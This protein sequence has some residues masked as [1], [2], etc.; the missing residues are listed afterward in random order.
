MLLAS[1]RGEATASVETPEEQVTDS[2]EETAKVGTD[3]VPVALVA[4]APA[5]TP[6]EDEEEDPADL[7]SALLE[8]VAPE[9]DA[10]EDEPSGDLTDA[11][12][13]D[14][15]DLQALVAEP[16]PPEPGEDQRPRVAWPT[17]VAAVDTVAESDDDSDDEEDVEDD[18]D[19]AVTGRD[20]KRRSRYRSRSAQLPRLGNQAKSNMTTM[21]NLRKKSRGAND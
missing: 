3:E 9:L 4:E 5:E 12:A 14:P 17:P 18:D 16:S 7:L 11:S 20:G 15:V 2:A 1:A 21:A 13:D 6:G 19:E 10:A 8:Q